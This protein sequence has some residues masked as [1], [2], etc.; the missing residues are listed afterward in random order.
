MRKY[1]LIFCL[2]I[3]LTGWIFGFLYHYQEEHDYTAIPKT[4]EES[5][6]T[7]RKEIFQNIFINNA[8]VVLINFAG[9]FSFGLISCVNVCYN[10]FVVGDVI[11]NGL[12]VLSSDTILRGILPH[13]FE[14]VGYFWSAL[15]GIE[16]GLKLFLYV[17]FQKPFTCSYKKLMFEL[18]LCILIMLTAAFVEAYVSIY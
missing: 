13:S 9:L 8:G 2:L 18:V 10:G 4:M 11:K 15:L 17:F 12:R 1:I 3:Y 7:E 5:L 6:G 16:T 14:L